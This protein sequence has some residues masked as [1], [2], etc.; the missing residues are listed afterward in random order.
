MTEY[1][2][3]IK[4]FLFLKSKMKIFPSEPCS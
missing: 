4:E 2:N 1:L 3:V